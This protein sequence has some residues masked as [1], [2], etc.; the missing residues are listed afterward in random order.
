MTA[1][2][3]TQTDH[4]KPED[5]DKRNLMGFKK[6]KHKALHPGQKNPT[7]QHRLGRAG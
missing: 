3:P 6:E 1:P 5:R 2:L 7:H 4:D